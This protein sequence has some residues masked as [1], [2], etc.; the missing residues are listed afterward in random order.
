[1][2]K[3][4]SNWVDGEKFFNREMD[5]E[6]LAERVREG[7]HTLLTAQRRMGKT[8]LVRELQRQLA[9]T[10][11]FEVVFVDL[12]AATDPA[13]A[14]AEIGVQAKSVGAAWD[15]IVTGFANLV[16]SAGDRIEELSV[17]DLKVKLR[18]G[19]DVGNWTHKGDAILTALADSSRPVVLAIDELPLLVNRLLKD[20]VGVSRRRGS[21]KQMRF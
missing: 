18:A 14:I 1:M 7:T 20:E 12:E 19:I 21:R 15:R 16:R 9:E 8:S 3:G 6:V 17:A 5:L 2:R 4:G 13:D 10:G 11:D